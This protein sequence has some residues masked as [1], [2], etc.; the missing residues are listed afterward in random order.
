MKISTDD[1]KKSNPMQ[2]GSRADDLSRAISAL[3]AELAK[4]DITSRQQAR[5]KLMSIGEPALPALIE[6]LE[7]G[8]FPLRWEIAKTLGEMGLQGSVPA[9]VKALEDEEQDV[10]WLAAMALAKIGREALPPLLE[11]LIARSDSPYLRQG[12][13]HVL[14]TYQDPQHG[15]LLLQVRDALSPM[16][17]PVD[18]IPAAQQALHALRS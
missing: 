1:S 13:H 16:Q 3:L 9:L 17:N 15:E 14:A 7:N 6:G 10:R 11:E 8:D 4:R 18:V 2:T 5:E 12:T